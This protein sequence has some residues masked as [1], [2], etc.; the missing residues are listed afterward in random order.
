MYK[1][2]EFSKLTNTNFYQH[3]KPKDLF[4]QG[5]I[6]PTKQR[7]NCAAKTGPMMKI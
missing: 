1:I 4:C 2:A 5:F 6:L 3:L 7:K